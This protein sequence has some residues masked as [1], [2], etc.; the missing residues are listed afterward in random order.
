MNPY[1]FLGFHITLENLPHVVTTTISLKPIAVTTA[2]VYQSPSQY[3]SIAGSTLV[4]INANN[5]IIINS[6]DNSYNT[7]FFVYKKPKKGFSIASHTSLHYG[8]S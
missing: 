4:K 8:S 2:N 1:C 3:V 5:N 7:F 6:P